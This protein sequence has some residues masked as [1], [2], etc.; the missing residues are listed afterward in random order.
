MTRIYTYAIFLIIGFFVW[1]GSAHAADWIAASERYF[2]YDTTPTKTTGK[3]YK[4]VVNTDIETPRSTW[5]KLSGTWVKYTTVLGGLKYGEEVII[6]PPPQ[7]TCTAFI[8]KD[9]F[10]ITFDLSQDTVLTC[11]RVQITKEQMALIY[12]ATKV[13]NIPPCR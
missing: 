7:P 12:D 1:F 8:C 9:D 10:G 11:P 6:Y 5:V 2:K 4:Y 3:V 13:N